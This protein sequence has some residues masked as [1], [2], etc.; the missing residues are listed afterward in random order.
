MGEQATI[1]LNEVT[2]LGGG[3]R[4]FELFKEPHPRLRPDPASAVTAVEI[5]CVVHPR[6]RGRH[7]LHLLAK[8]GSTSPTLCGYLGNREQVLVQTLRQPLWST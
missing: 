6:E 3:F 7:A 1:R 4:T 2:R 5:E 8:A